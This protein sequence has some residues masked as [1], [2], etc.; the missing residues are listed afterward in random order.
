[1]PRD[2]ARTRIKRWIQSY[3]RFGTV[4]DIKVCNHNGRY[5]IEVEVQSLFQ[6]QTVSWIRFVNG[7]DKICQRSHADPRGREKASGKPAAKA[8]PILKPSSIGDV[9]LYPYWT[10]TID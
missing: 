1:M 2:Q 10:E 9:K 7:I 6:D 5:S 4:S 3:V 8:R